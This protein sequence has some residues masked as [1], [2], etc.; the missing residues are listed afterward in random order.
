MATGTQE[1]AVKAVSARDTGVDNGTLRFI[2][3]GSVNDGKSTLIGRLLWDSRL[4]FEDQRARFE[5]ENETAGRADAGN[6]DFSLLVDG[7]SAEREQGIT[8]DV[9][10]RYFRTGKRS[11]IVADTPGHPQ[12]TRNMATGASNAEV[13]V[14]LVDGRHGV[15][16]Q[17]RRH[18]AIAHAMGIRQMAVAVNKM[19]LIGWDDRRFREIEEAC[20]DLAM[21]LG[22]GHVTIIPV[23]A[24]CGD[25]VFDRSSKMGWHQG[26]T[27]MEFLETV[28]ADVDV[29]RG[30]GQAFRFPVQWVNRPDPD[31]RG[32]SGTMRGGT[33]RP[34]DAV[35]VWPSGV[36]ACVDR[37]VTYD[38]DI[39]E[40]GDGDAVTLVLDREIDVSRGDLFAGLGKAPI[41]VA[42]Q[43]QAKLIW[44]GEENLAPGRNYLVRFGA[45]T[46]TGRVMT[47][48]WRL[49]VET[50]A[51]LGARALE[52]NDIG[53]VTLSLDRA[54]PIDSYDE[55]RHT[56]SFVLIDRE[57]NATVAAG[58]VEFPL[59]RATNVVWHEHAVDKSV[60]GANKN[61]KQRCV[62][63]TGLSGSGKSTI[64]NMLDKRLT[65]ENHHSY[66]L[67]GDNLRHGLN[68]DLGF[69][70]AGRIENIRRMAEVAKLM[71]DAG[72]I[73]M[74]CAISPYRRDREMARTLFEADEF[75]E[76][77][78]DTSLSE[79]ER[80][81]PKG[82]YQK[83]RLNLIPNFTGISAPYEPPDSPE[84]RL[85]GTRPVEDLVEQILVRVGR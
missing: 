74:V 56:G 69:T 14:I 22:I 42:D 58:M 44:V 75:I 55:N 41:A 5:K 24:L 45:A 6:M 50:S 48:K 33:V 12:Y 20:V 32:Y 84:F 54:L 27:L 30:A 85:D 60:R 8:I 62:W 38:G 11:F 76:I 78:V 51:H 4:L 40:A 66:V 83:A 7:L 79:C 64:A 10:Y 35:C 59:R 26:P 65:A 57:T 25:N 21:D 9:A 2:T 61:Q 31:F 13:A 77:F 34:G 18:A 23:S 73:V 37:I 15:R 47:V 49:N 3:C 16:A 43:I 53:V 68:K 28:D 80:R 36:Q 46:A 52:C 72:L 39:P 63:F 17:T 1:T 82:L 81:D 29:D 19:D 67:D 71:V 70:E